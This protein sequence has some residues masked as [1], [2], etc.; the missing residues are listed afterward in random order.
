MSL[1][2]RSGLTSLAS[3]AVALKVHYNIDT[4]DLGGLV[5][6]SHLVERY[7]GVKIP[8]NSPVL[9]SH[10]FSHKAGVH[11]AAVLK[12]PGTY[13]AFPP[14]LIKRERRIIVDK[15]TGRSAVRS[16]LE[17]LGV[18]LDE[19]KLSQ[20]VQTI[21]NDQVRSS[22]SDADILNLAQQMNN[23]VIASTNFQEANK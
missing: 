2:E 22:Y 12:D 9:G 5:A 16:R 19:H 17:K 15:Y 6:L 4:V 3:L 11:T 1:G 7:S 20:V 18:T 23:S 10:A 21:K 14:S 13:E 8:D